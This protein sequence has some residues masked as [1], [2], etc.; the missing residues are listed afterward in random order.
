MTDI[1]RVSNCRSIVFGEYWDEND[2]SKRVE[3]CKKG[4]ECN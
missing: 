2:V 3:I 1:Y 4:D